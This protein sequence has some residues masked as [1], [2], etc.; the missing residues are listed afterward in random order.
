M[1][2][3]RRTTFFLIVALATLV[4]GGAVVSRQLRP[5]SNVERRFEP[6]ALERRLFVGG[7]HGKIHVYDIDED[8]RHLGRIKV[9]GADKFKGI[10]ASVKHQA[11]YVTSHE[12]D[13]LLCIDVATHE[14]RW[15]RRYGDYLD[16]L[17]VTADGDTLYVPARDGVPWR[18]YVVDA[19]NGDVRT[20]VEID[21][22]PKDPRYKRKSAKERNEPPWTTSRGP[23]NTVRGAGGTRMYLE[24]MQSPYV[25]VADTTTHAIVGRIG[26]FSAGVRPLAVFADERRVAVSVDGLLGFEIGAV[27]APDGSIGGPMLHNVRAR[28]GPE[29]RNEVGKLDDLPHN[30]PSH[31]VAIHPNQTEIWAVDGAYGFLHVFDATV[32]PP[33]A[34]TSIA[35]FEKAKERPDPGW[36][37]FSLDGAYAYSGTGHVVDTAT[38]RVIDRVEESERIIELDFRDGV[39]V[40]ASQR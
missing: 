39:L 29:R 38:K 33:V 2:L 22:P 21:P 12:T 37:T 16:S 30:T 27:Y 10:A 7:S 6:G 11:L 18:W 19:A 36:I 20:T 31:G 23:H 3:S 15:R 5:G 35:L 8:H 32:D 25:Y 4:A 17:A 14:E 1:A 24:A 28:P 9:R 40:A 13:H 26:P 34:K